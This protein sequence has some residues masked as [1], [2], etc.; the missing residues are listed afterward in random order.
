MLLGLFFTPEDGSPDV[1]PKHPSYNGLH[2]V[3]SQKTEL[4]TSTAV[5]TPN[6]T[7][8]QDVTPFWYLAVTT[9][10]PG[11]LGRTKVLPA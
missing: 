5:T 3:I 8:R 4:F 10:R 1:P 11:S 9:P 6:P 7:L 2:G